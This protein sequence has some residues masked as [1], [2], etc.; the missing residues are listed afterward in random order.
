MLWLALT[1][2]APGVGRAADLNPTVTGP[3]ANA[4]RDE[5]EGL[6]ETPG[7]VDVRTPDAVSEF[8]ES[9]GLAPVW[10]DE[11]LDQLVIEIGGLSL[12]GLDPG[13]Y[14]LTA[15]Q[16]ARAK[17]ANDTPATPDHWQL[18]AR[19]DVTATRACLRAL[20][21][22]HEGKL[23]PHQLEPRW[24]FEHQALALQPALASAAGAIHREDIASLFASARPQH[25]IYGRLRAALSRLYE[26]RAAG[27]WPILPDGDTLKPG[28]HDPRVPLLRARL[29]AAGNLAGDASD[30]GDFYGSELEA[31]VR[32]FQAEQYLE[33][34]GAVGRK[35]RAALA[36][37]VENRIDQLRVNLERLRWVLPAIGG[38]LVLVDI[39]GYR[40][41]YFR[42]SEPA[43][44]SRV[45]IGRPYRQTP[46][47][48]DEITYL[49]FNPPWTVPPTI[50]RED[51]LPRQRRDPGYL[52]RNHIRVFN[53]D[54]RE[55][56]PSSIDWNHPG[57]IT[58][59]QDP[60]PDGTLGPV[61]IRFPNPYDV[62]LHGTPHTEL[63][64][65]A[66]RAFSSGCI[67]VEEPLE[68]ARL[69]LND[70]VHWGADAIAAVVASGATK[71]VV[72]PKPIPVALLYWTV[73]VRADGRVTYKPDIYDRDPPTLA[74]LDA[75]QPSR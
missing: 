29:I 30:T 66:Q 18:A 54:G 20:R 23:D 4:I 6:R 31:A 48:Q 44:S 61:V 74:A 7:G 17:L 40:V 64:A 50:L 57:A 42:G 55:V 51:I 26:I 3:V 32:A 27:G 60:G 14:D 52:A 69:L 2:I 62:Y 25:P 70:P 63:F 11:T 72:L 19:L 53:R 65:F 43:W 36:V 34:D 67:R 12:D 24:N 47:F 38:N 33:V 22:L 37:P 45:V 58:L 73:D 1:L 13:D 71:T 41:W 39:A 5:I 68:L 10:R 8:Y 49:V 56:P 59:R 15:I 35:T 9:R 21:H 28:M 75:K 16:S 46:V